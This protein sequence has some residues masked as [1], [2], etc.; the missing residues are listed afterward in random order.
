MLNGYL[1]FVPVDTTVVKFAPLAFMDPYRYIGMNET[2]VDVKKLHDFMMG[3]TT[4]SEYQKLRP[5]IRD[6][7]I[8]TWKAEKLWLRDKT[9][10]TQYLVWRYIGTANGVFRVTPGAVQ[11][12]SYDPRNRPWLV[13]GLQ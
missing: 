13:C 5:D 7:V 10:L 6:T 4:S 3:R 11:Q 1:H 9:E 8:A 12:Q 2:T